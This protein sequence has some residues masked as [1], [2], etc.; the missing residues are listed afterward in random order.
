MKWSIASLLLLSTVLFASPD[1]ATTQQSGG[2]VYKV[3]SLQEGF[4]HKDGGGIV[5]SDP[6]PEGEVLADGIYF[7]P[8]NGKP[9]EKGQVSI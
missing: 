7:R 9:V 5:L 4:E 1:D 8:A 3:G 2:V 6:I